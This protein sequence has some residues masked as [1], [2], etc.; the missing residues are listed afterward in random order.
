[1]K[2]LKIFF[3]FLY[4]MILLVPIFMFNFKENSISEIDNRYLANNPFGNNYV[5]EEGYRDRTQEI[6]A[7][8]Q[9][10]I[11]LRDKMIL[12][13]TVLNDKLFHK[14]VHPN[15][16]YGKDGY[17]FFKVDMNKKYSDF[18]KS[19]VDMVVKIQTYCD[20]RGIPFVFVFNPA[21]ISVFRDKLPAGINYNNEWVHEFMQALDAQGVNYVDNTAVMIDKSQEG[22]IV[23]NKVYNAGH[24]NDRGAFYGV[25]EILKNL[26]IIFPGIHINRLEDF[27][28]EDKL[29]TSL[30]GLRFPIHEY[31]PVFTPLCE[32]NEKTN[33][34]DSEVKR[35]INYSSFGYYINLKQ[36]A[37]GS[38]KVLV[39]Q[40]SYMN[41]MGY[42][43][44]Q[45]SLGE[46]I[47]IHDYQNILD[48][49]YYFNIFQP[50]CVVLE[51]AEYTFSDMYF[52]YEKMKNMRLNPPLKSFADIEI[53]E[54]KI[55]NDMLKINKGERLTIYTVS[56]MADTTA[57]AYILLNGKEFDLIKQYDEYG[58]MY[59]M[60][61]VENTN[62]ETKNV[63]LYAVD[64]INGISTIFTY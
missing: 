14:M 56:N 13:Y 26:K 25:N 45:N 32:L 63:E 17:V 51:V 35:D 12:I 40:G 47:N 18:E 39:F 33:E 58:D 37:E 2:K 34:Y 44:L 61:T 6:E 9:D 29:N 27:T 50:D 59:Y 57:F 28:I 43:F 20:E 8:V 24:W 62:F 42:K 46:Y 1:M 15:Y 7:Y 16:T 60:A 10:R 41:G 3:I 19:F 53:I 55:T 36:K 21:K 23:F 38:P 4:F 54:S 30:S 11:G 52:N 64:T 5:S 31:E 22:E 48:F 49:P